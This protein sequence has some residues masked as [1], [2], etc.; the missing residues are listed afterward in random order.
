[1]T[2][3]AARLRE[4]AFE[5]ARAQHH[6]F[7][8]VV[9]ER[10]G[11]TDR[12]RFTGN[13]D[14]GFS[15][16][17]HPDCVLVR[18]AGDETSQCAFD[19]EMQAH[20]L[21]DWATAIRGAEDQGTLLQ[22]ADDLNLNADALLAAVRH[23]VGAVQP[24]AEPL[25]LPPQQLDALEARLSAARAELRHFKSS[26]SDVDASLDNL[27][28]LLARLRSENSDLKLQTADL[29]REVGRLSA[30]ATPTQEWQRHLAS[31]MRKMLPPRLYAEVLEHL[32]PLTPFVQF[33]REYDAKVPAPAPPQEPTK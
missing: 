18:E 10:P 4:L 16:C 9:A 20:H 22:I 19:H 8:A 13:Y 7:A 1:M 33:L 6:A 30:G 17:P 29:F 28:W 25:E 31:A 24:A 12:H 23:E 14:D 26:Y 5:Q 27:G 32:D 3:G 15:T 2:E 21:R 11:G